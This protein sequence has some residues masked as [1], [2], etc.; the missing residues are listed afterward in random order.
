MSKKIVIEAPQVF[1]LDY[2]A[3][4][5]ECSLRKDAGQIT[6]M[7]GMKMCRDCEAK[8]KNDHLR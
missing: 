5:D 1:V 7:F 2:P 8:F 3:V 4:C 6:Q